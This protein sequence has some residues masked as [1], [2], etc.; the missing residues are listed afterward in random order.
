MRVIASAFAG[1]AAAFACALPAAAG[2]VETG[3]IAPSYLDPNHAEYFYSWDS[4]PLNRLVL[5]LE[6]VL[7]DGVAAPTSTTLFDEVEWGE[8]YKPD[9]SASNEYFSGCTGPLICGSEFLPSPPGT[10]RIRYTSYWGENATSIFFPVSP[11]RITFTADFADAIAEG[12]FDAS[13]R[14]LSVPEPA[15]WAVMLLGF[16]AVGGELRRRRR[17]A[18]A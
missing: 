9:P 11:V 12:P 1:A 2:V 15:T 16:G 8:F 4:D 13:Y 3:V 14:I 5:E 18:S 7:K 17:L 6:F 10:T